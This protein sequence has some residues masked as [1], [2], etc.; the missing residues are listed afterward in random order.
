MMVG[1]TSPK[2]YSYI[3]FSTPDQN[4]GTSKERQEEMALEYAKKMALAQ[5]YAKEA[6][7]PLDTSLDLKDLGLSAFHG[8]HRRRGSLGKFMELV[9]DGC[10][11]KGSILAVES[12][13]RLSREGPYDAFTQLS[14]IINNGISVKTFQ[15][16]KFITREILNEHPGELYEIL[17]VMIR[18]NEESTTKSMRLKAARKSNR[19]AARRGQEILTGHFVKWVKPNDQ[20]SGFEIIPERAEVI[21][22]IFELTLAGW[23]SRKI[24]KDLNIKGIPSW[25]KSNGWRESY[26]KKII[27]NPAVIG[28][29]QPY[30]IKDD[31]YDKR[32][33]VPEGEP[34]IGYY[35]R[36]ISDEIFYQVKAKLQRNI[37]KGGQTGKV[38]NLLSHL[39]KCPFCGASMAYQPKGDP[40]KG[41]KYLVC[42]NARR[43]INCKAIKKVPVRYELVEKAILTYCKGLRAEDILPRDDTC[44]S[45]IKTQK[46]KLNSIAGQISHIQT[47]ITNDL[48]DRDKFTKNESMRVTLLRR[49]EQ[50]Q[51]KLTAFEKEHADATKMLGDLEHAREST[52]E[53]IEGIK[54]LISLLFIDKSPELR[55]RV[56]TQLRELI[57]KIEVFGYGT[58]K[59]P[60]Y[61]MKF[62]LDERII[63]RKTFESTDRTMMKYIGPELQAY[64]IYFKSGVVREIRPRLGRTI[65]VEYEKKA[66]KLISRIWSFD[67]AGKMVKEIILGNKDRSGLY[68]K[69]PKEV[70]TLLARD[71]EYNL[72]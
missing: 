29:C 28:I 45:E 50:N 71:I 40:P 10:I 62:L 36:V 72:L 22:Q 30:V 19:E 13:D 41:G 64:R 48:N 12:L 20:S 31:E 63:T 16:K 59:N 38:S 46:A 39:V 61:P 26:I 25:G 7:L 24:A 65:V 67:E 14:V 69:L 9:K 15:P 42:D 57:E 60:V 11:P 49:A 54:G 27:R 51:E 1:E 70:S 8:A 35:P 53:Q 6:K 66:D 2:I 68:K 55:L 52:L 34:I 5:K 32:V 18:A 47:V 43:G 44:K 17:G 56:R 3:R 37:K 23:G 21:K 33:R 4:K 58:K